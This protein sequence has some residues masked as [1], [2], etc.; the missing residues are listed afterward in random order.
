MGAP[1]I[2]A[3][4]SQFISHTRGEFRAQ[5]G[6][7][8]FFDQEGEAAFGTG[9]ARAMIAKNLDQL[10]YGGRRLIDFD[11]DVQVRSDGESA[12]AHLSAYEHIKADS[13]ALLCGN[14]RDVLRLVMRT[15]V[16][17][18]GNRDVELARQVRELRVAL[19][20]DDETVQLVHD[21]GGVK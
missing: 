8:P 6:D 14:E 10:N 20:P 12:G 7:S 1:H 5:S 19:A 15:V 18:A 2:P 16:Q 21:R 17:T 4:K 3:L 11:E 9:L 13:P